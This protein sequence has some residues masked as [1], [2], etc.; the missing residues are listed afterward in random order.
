MAMKKIR[1]SFG[2]E[3]FEINLKK[4]EFIQKGFGLMFT[5]RERARALLFEFSK[6]T[7]LAITSWFVF[8]P[9]VAIWL[10]EEGRIIQIQKVKPFENSV[11]PKEKFV[12]LI[13]IP[14]N[15]KYFRIISSLVGS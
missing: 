5:S 12:K 3:K 2:K 15:K 11:K 8:F 10:N 7:K 9:F 4:C 6:P 14:V 13:E 1:L